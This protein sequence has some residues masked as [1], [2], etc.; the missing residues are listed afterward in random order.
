MTVI[1][2]VKHLHIIVCDHQI[3]SAPLHI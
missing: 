1:S 3:K 2:I